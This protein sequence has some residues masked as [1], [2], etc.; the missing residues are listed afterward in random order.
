VAKKAKRARG[1]HTAVVLQPDVLESLR[2]SPRGV[3][4]EIRHRINRT[5]YEDGFDQKT[6]ELAADIMEIANELHRQTGVTWHLNRGAHQALVEAV[7]WWLDSIK[8][9][10]DDVGAV[11]DLF[12][13]DPLTRGQSVAQSWQRIKAE[14]AKTDQEIINL[15]EGDKS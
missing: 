6:R 13:G 4:N 9:P 12:V 14:I 10:V 15:H 8:P 11:S 5:L 1:V 2:Q 3:S 7:R